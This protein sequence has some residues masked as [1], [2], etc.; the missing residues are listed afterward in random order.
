VSAGV[1]EVLRGDLAYLRVLIERRL[2]TGDVVRD[3]LVLKAC[4][5]VF[6]ERRQRLHAL[7]AATWEPQTTRDVGRREG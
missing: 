7:E 4:A 5:E 3:D 6:A 2:D 1:F